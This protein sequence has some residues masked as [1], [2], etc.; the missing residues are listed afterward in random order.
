[1][2]RYVQCLLDH[3][4]SLLYRPKLLKRLTES[5]KANIEEYSDSVLSDPSDDFIDATN[6]LIE[7]VALCCQCLL[8]FSPKLLNLLCDV[9]F[10]QS[11]WVPFI[12]VQ[13]GAPKIS[14]NPQLLSYGSILSIIAL[15]IKTLNLQHFNFKQ[16]PLNKIPEFGEYENEYGNDTVSMIS[17]G[18]S[19]QQLGLTTPATTSPSPSKSKRPF[20]KSLSISS[21]TS[22]V[23]QPSNEL[24]LHIDTRMCLNA[25]ELLLTLLASQSLLALK[26]RQLS[27]REKQMI[28]R[29]LSTE[30]YCFH[31]FVKKKILKDTT[32]SPLF[33]QKVGISYITNSNANNDDNDDQNAGTSSRA[34]LSQRRSHDLRVN[35][36]RKLHLQ[37]KTVPFEVPHTI[38]PISIHHVT[39]TKDQN[40]TNDGTPFRSNL[41][42]PTTSTHVKRVGFD[43]NSTQVNK[44]SVQEYD[45]E[46]YAVNIGD[47]TFTG[48][49]FI[50]FIEE[51][52]LQLLSNIFLFICQNEN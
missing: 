44:I 46:P 43:L 4:V 5:S 51:D 15:L 23:I 47:P 27:S 28:R 13:F 49:S 1:M 41:G 7:V 2:Q 35:V 52:Y 17:I 16:T 12:E 39:Q 3:A 14:G 21:M 29:E 31:D 9:E 38:S 20:S 11:K 19:T 8:H 50:K 10:H 37:Q 34:V 22:S 25:L 45:D 48:L 32:K 36:V 40:T 18:D 24:L 6:G 42:N 33:R 30:L 26:A